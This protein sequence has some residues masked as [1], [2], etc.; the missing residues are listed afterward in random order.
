MSVITEEEVWKFCQRH[1][2]QPHNFF[3]RLS[4]REVECRACGAKEGE[5]CRRRDRRRIGNH[6]ERCFDRIRLA[7]ASE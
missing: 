5:S 1:G 6:L 3:S 7:I 2:C 4:V